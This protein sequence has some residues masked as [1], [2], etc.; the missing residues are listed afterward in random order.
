MVFAFKRLRSPLTKP[1]KG[2]FIVFTRINQMV[3]NFIIPGITDGTFDNR[4]QSNSMQLLIVLS[5]YLVNVSP[6][7]QFRL[8]YVAPALWSL[9]RFNTIYMNFPVRSA[10]W[11]HFFQFNVFH[12]NPP[13]LN[14]LQ[15]LSRESG[16]HDATFTVYNILPFDVAFVTSLSEILRA[17]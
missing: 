13:S 16:S 4:M 17:K 1:N 3:V 5:G 8:F 12:E 7:E 14:V 10:L 15:K 6:S 11:K 2:I 9:L